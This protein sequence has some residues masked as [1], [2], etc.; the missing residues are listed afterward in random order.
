MQTDAS[1]RF[2]RGTDRQRVT[3]ALGRATQLIQEIAGGEVTK[4]LLD[5]QTNA[6]EPAPI[7][8]EIKRVNALL[9]LNLSSTEIADYLVYLGFEIRRSERETLVVV[10]PTYRV[11]ITRDVD[12]IEEVARLHNYNNIPSTMPRVVAHTR[13]QS[14]LDQII[15]SGRDTLVGYGFCE[16]M[17]FS[18]VSEQEAARMGVDPACQPRLA[19]PLS[20]DWA[21]MRPTLLGGLLTSAAANQ[22]VDEQDIRL[23]EISKTWNP[24]SG[25]G[26][27]ESEG[28][29]LALVLAGPTPLAWTAPARPRDFYDLKGI[30]EG[31]LEHWSPGEARLEPLADSPVYHPGRSARIHWRGEAIGELGELHPD[32]ADG[33][34]LR[35]RVYIAR[36]DL[37]KAAAVKSPGVPKFQSIPRYPGS[38]RDLALVVDHAV[39]AGAIEEEVRKAAK[40]VLEDFT[41]FDVYEGEKIPASKKSLALRLRLRSAE[42]TLT[43]ED[44]NAVMEKVIARLAKQFGA[45]L[46]A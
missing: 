38:W 31:V 12:L 44:I 39:T 3:L 28:R 6:V 24:A 34:D 17:N 14:A 29:E 11:D 7:V 1:Y 20:V 35:G 16:A 8:L 46:R 10:A 33:Y 36:I 15:E 30:V 42:K 4:G 25:P 43:E 37:L 2:E 21:V 26:K 18:F 41:I 5:L 13:E 9:G 23:F 32:L 22:K 27:P 45:T 40:P 19:N